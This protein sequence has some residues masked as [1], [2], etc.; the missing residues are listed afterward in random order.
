MERGGE[1]WPAW[2]DCIDRFRAALAALL[3]GHEREYCPQPNLSAA[4]AKLLP[5]LPKPPAGKRVWLASE[6]AFPSLGDYTSEP[7]GLA[8]MGCRKESSI[9][10]RTRH[11]AVG[12]R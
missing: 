11:L 7:P 4:L 1:A 2:L 6:E 3:G 10:R 9:H 5:A 12:H 8:R